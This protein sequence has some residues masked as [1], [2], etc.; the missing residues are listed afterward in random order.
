MRLFGEVVA[1][2]KSI[3]SP[4]P[5]RSGGSWWGIVRESFTGAW[6]RNVVCES[7][8]NVCGFSPVY[9]C[10]SLI[11]GDIA[12]LRIKLMELVGGIWV[13]VTN[14]PAFL[15]VL[16]K[17]NR[18]QT[19]I[20]F[21]SQWIVSK[22]LY[23]NTYVL[24][25]RD[26][27]GVVVALYVL[28]PRLTLPLVAE[29]G[30]V[31]Y[32]V[33][34]DN[35]A[36]VAIGAPVV[37]ASEII[38]DRMLCL[39]HPLVGISPIFACASSATQ[40]IRIQA[41]SVKFFENMSRPSGQLTAPGAI[42]DENALRLKQEFEKNFAGANIGRLLVTGDGLKYEP[43]AMP[44]DQAQ[45]IEQLRWT[46][47]DCARPFHVPA[48]KLGLAQPTLTS[49]AALNQ[50]YY[51]QC[52]QTHI[53]S[54]ELCLTEG[55]G[56]Q[57]VPNKVYA[58]ELDLDGLLRMDPL[59]MADVLEKSTRG[60]VMAPDEARQKL[61]LPPVPGGQYPYA[62]M[63]NYSLGALA[64]RDAQDD[65]FASKSPTQQQPLTTAPTE[66]KAFDL[67][68]EEIRRLAVMELRLALVNETLH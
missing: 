28:D 8:Q 12:K 16:R 35:L 11:Q 27:R 24:K 4:V 57:D 9:T 49:V 33:G 66:D 62:Q 41:N 6:Q 5:V 21:I 54:L 60:F 23:G 36:G 46:A 7:T 26:Q 19:R 34:A 44:A 29:D 39:W 63:Q 52:L 40:G 61:N 32:Q 30:G 50:D 51:S 15:P 58:A 43:L 14:S 64:K 55:L 2:I 42:S 25:E 67:D 53:E 22:L 31:Y 17:P 48:Y 37:P 18:Y 65:P 56:L 68:D 45:L 59:T 20:Q 1:R 38:H 3:L 13:E 47:E 10:I